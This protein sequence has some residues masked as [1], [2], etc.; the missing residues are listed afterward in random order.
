MG[1]VNSGR[2]GGEVADGGGG[3]ELEGWETSPMALS[4]SYKKGPISKWSNI[5]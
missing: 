3:C 2:D 1:R 4:I 5:F